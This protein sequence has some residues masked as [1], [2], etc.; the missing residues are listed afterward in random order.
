M[1]VEYVS[2]PSL[3]EPFTPAKAFNFYTYNVY[4]GA[5]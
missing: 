5:G 3:R 1:D 4:G 2:V